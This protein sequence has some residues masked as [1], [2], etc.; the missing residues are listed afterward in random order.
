MN[1]QL[2]A[3]FASFLVEQDYISDSNLVDTYISCLSAKRLA[4]QLDE[5]YY[6]EDWMSQHPNPENK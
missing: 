5:L 6:Y 3:R 4:E 1:L 2:K